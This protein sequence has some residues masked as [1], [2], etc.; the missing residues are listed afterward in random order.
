MNRIFIV[1]W[2]IALLTLSGTLSGCAGEMGEFMENAAI[3][4][5]HEAQK[6]AKRKQKSP[7][8]QKKPSAIEKIKKMRAVDY[9]GPGGTECSKRKGKMYTVT[10]VHKGLNLTIRGV[11]NGKKVYREKLTIPESAYKKDLKWK[12]GKAVARLATEDDTGHYVFHGSF[13][14]NAGCKVAYK[15][16]RVDRH[17]TTLQ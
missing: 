3:N 4:A 2:T 13:R 8:A 12:K 7:V 9:A 5:Q 17:Y 6:A 1:I 10:A 14:D 11:V 16:K 15:I